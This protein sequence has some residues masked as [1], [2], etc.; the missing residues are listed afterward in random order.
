MK[1]PAFALVG[2]FTLFAASL[3]C[4]QAAPDAVFLQAGRGDGT[5]S[6]TAGIDWDF[7][8]TWRPGNV[9]ID[10]YWDL[11]VAHWRTDAESRSFS[12]SQ[13]GITPVFRLRM[14]PDSRWFTEA[15]IGLTWTTARYRSSDKRFT[16]NFNFA[17]HVA[18]GRIFGQSR[19][20]IVAL[21]YEHFSNGGIR[22]PN[23]GVNFGQLRYTYRF[24]DSHAS[25]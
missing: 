25:R 15:G 14:S 6:A 20:H 8:R 4:A 3:G 2:G 5:T 1:G 9:L 11:S 10:G 19:R 21:R 23:P 18:L 17:D 7:A 22:R 16:T 24:G 12:L 13:V